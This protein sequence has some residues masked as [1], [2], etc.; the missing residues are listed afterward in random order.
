MNRPSAS[1]IHVGISTCPND[2][3]AFHA[4]MNRLVD[5]RGLDFRFDLL[6]I[7][8]LNGRLHQ[9]HF[10]V[11]KTSFHAA[12]KLSDRTVVLPSGSAL[13]F[14]VG[15]LLLAARTGES[16]DDAGRLTLCPGADTTATLLMKL[17]YPG[18]NRLDQVIFSDIMP[19]LKAASA[20][21][22]VCIHEGRFTWEVEGLHLIEDLG[23]RW[24]SETGMPLP[25]GGLVARRSLPSETIEK[26]QACV[27]DSILWANANR[28]LTLPTM[29]HHAQEFDDDVLM[30]HVDLYVN[31]WTVDLGDEGTQALQTLS[32]RAMRAGVEVNDNIP[33]QVFSRQ[34]RG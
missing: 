3:Y 17:F 13:G 6:D 30:Q 28:D 22:G 27:R 15:P 34:V 26:T 19:R 10:D 2:T 33:L 23:A 25:L 4:L 24:E 29:R 16:P 12:I 32:R 9:G 5:W 31:A 8:E 14:G 18:A 21:F 7:Q 20:D 11:A 1:S